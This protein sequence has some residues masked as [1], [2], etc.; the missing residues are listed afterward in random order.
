[1][2]VRPG[3]KLPACESLIEGKIRDRDTPLPHRGRS[4]RR[5]TRRRASGRPCGPSTCARPATSSRSSTRFC[6]ATM[7]RADGPEPDRAEHC[8]ARAYPRTPG[9]NPGRDL[10][11]WD[12]LGRAPALPRC[13][14]RVDDP[15]LA[16]PLR[17][18]RGFEV[19]RRP[20]RHPH[21]SD[22][23]NTWSAAQHAGDATGRTTHREAPPRTPRATSMD[24][25]SST[26][27]VAVG[28]GPASVSRM[29]ART[30]AS[31]ATGASASR[32]CA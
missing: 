8:L 30:A 22:A 2:A 6:R 29:A 12:L 18:L 32:R 16:R 1:M 24:C 20:L 13:P 15:S 19:P 4:G 9:R 5:S 17:R 10:I 25:A 21:S 14:S 31:N 11:G 23:T 3:R 28:R 26:A 7:A 27:F